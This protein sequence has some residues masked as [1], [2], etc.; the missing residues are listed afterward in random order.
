MLFIDN[1][2]P[3]ILERKPLLHQG[4]RPDHDRRQRLVAHTQFA[5]GGVDFA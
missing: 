2:E 3:D 5:L 1:G 4:M